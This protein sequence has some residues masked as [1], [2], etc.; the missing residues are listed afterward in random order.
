MAKTGKESGGAAG[1]GV[2]AHRGVVSYVVSTGQ[3]VIQAQTWSRLSVH[4]GDTGQ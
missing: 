1:E 4:G 3:S 2:Q